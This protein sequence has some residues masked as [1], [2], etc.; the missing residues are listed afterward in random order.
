MRYYYAYDLL[1][2]YNSANTDSFENL[3]DL[4]DDLIQFQDSK[5]VILCYF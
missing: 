3:D 1:R 5:K 4:F 2:G